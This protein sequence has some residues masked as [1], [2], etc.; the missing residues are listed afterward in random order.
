LLL[1]SPQG[2]VGVKTLKLAAGMALA[3]TVFLFAF[4]DFTPYVG[5]PD[6][7][8][9]VSPPSPASQ[10]LESV[11]VAVPFAVVSA[12]LFTVTG[13]LVPGFPLPRLILVTIP[14]LF[15]LVYYY[16]PFKLLLGGEPP[17]LVHYELPWGS[18]R[19]LISALGAAGLVAVAGTFAWACRVATSEAAPVRSG[20]SE[21]PTQRT[22]L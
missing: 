6:Q 9:W 22:R 3:N 19:L 21:E 12:L 17:Y 14:G 13:L 1:I 5:E 16:G 10:L 20:R 15:V 8:V 11:S 7:D 18:H 4:G 2:G